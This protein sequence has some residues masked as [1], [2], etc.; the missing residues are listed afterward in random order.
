[1]KRWRKEN[2]KTNMQKKRERKLRTIFVCVSI[3]KWV[4]VLATVLQSVF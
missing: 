1:M 3:R 4:L 2:L